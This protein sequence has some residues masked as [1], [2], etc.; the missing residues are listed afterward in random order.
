[1]P[2]I[3]IANENGDFT[4]G[5]SYR[6]SGI[7]PMADIYTGDSTRDRAAL[8]LQVVELIELMRR[9]DEDEHSTHFELT[10]I[11]KKLREILLVID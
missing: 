10:D 7:L 4:S 8:Q 11:R 3:P 5:Y 6:F 9:R 1:M 2:P